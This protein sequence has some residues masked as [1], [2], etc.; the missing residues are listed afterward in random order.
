M[1]VFFRGGELV[2][3]TGLSCS[4]AGWL[5]EFIDALIQH[6]ACGLFIFVGKYIK[7]Q[8]ITKEIIAYCS[9]QDFP[10]FVLPWNVHL[11]DIMQDYC[12]RLLHARQK[13][14]E[15][16]RL[17]RSL[18]ATGLHQEQ[19]LQEL[20]AL[21]LENMP[22]FLFIFPLKARIADEQQQSI[23]LDWKRHLNHLTCHYELFF[24]KNQLVLLLEHFSMANTDFLR[25]IEASMPAGIF[26]GYAGQ[27][28]VHDSWQE[29]SSAYEEA[30]TA[31]VAASCQKKQPCL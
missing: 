22:F 18:L 2:V 15:L 11:A 13:E 20:Q 28:A 9:E 21:E 27:S 25:D 10:L 29:L 4:H 7:E 5:R 17:L 8:D 1:P 16:T 26:Q 23:R 3:T 6:Q 24:Y 19:A 31:A 12:T 30:C 14:M